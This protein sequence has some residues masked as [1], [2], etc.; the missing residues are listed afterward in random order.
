MNARMSKNDMVG[1]NEA[2]LNAGIN[3]LVDEASTGIR[4]S[5]RG[6]EIQLKIRAV[7][8][9]RNVMTSEDCYEAVGLI[10]LVGDSHLKTS[11]HPPAVWQKV[12]ND[13]GHGA[14]SLGL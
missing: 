3:G 4:R 14:P 6:V 9:S 5:F 8:S 12:V 7:T 13:S 11:V 1:N 10:D 2:L